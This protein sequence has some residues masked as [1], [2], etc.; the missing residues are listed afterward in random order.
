[1]DKDLV[2]NLLN[3]NFH[4]LKIKLEE[5]FDQVIKDR[6]EMRDFIF[7]IMK[8]FFGIDYAFFTRNC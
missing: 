5:E 8:A 7:R 3:N 1:M 6:S 2:D 4:L